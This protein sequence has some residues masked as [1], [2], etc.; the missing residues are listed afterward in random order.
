MSDLIQ[1]ASIRTDGGCQPRAEKL[2][3]VI[4][5]YAAAMVQGSEFPPITVFYD[6][7]DYWLA[8]G[9]HRRDAA[10]GAGKTEILADVRQGTRRDAILFSVGAN[11]A[12]GLR[13]TNEDKRR[14]VMTLLAD[15]E[16]AAWS[17]REIA[18][19]CV[20]SYEL[21]RQHRPKPSV[22]VNSDSETAA[23]RTYVTRHGTVSTMNT[24]RIGGNRP[25]F[26]RSDFAQADPGEHDAVPPKILGAEDTDPPTSAVPILNRDLSAEPERDKSSDHIWRGVQAIVDAFKTLPPPTNAAAKFPRLFAHSVRAEDVTAAAK[27][28]A[29][30]ALLWEAGQP[31]RD[32][33]TRD[34]VDQA[35][36]IIDS[37]V[38]AS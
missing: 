31:E 35:Q 19:R 9:Y 12:H 10:I 24:A 36:G 2:L 30:F 3:D 33:R 21:V 17:D 5:D 11:A 28:L 20:V 27:W 29:E 25:V 8:D 37:H 1:I 13:R 7:A 23:P 15:P 22:T 26:D 34:F 32:A 6:G 38:I 16:W 14:S 18:R 4:D